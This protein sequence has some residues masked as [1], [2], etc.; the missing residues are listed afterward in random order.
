MTQQVSFRISHCSPCWTQRS[1]EHGTPT[2]GLQDLE[3]V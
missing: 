2:L 1:Q 3:F